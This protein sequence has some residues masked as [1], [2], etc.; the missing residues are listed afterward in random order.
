[1]DRLARHIAVDQR[2]R[3]AFG[4]V[5]GGLEGAEAGRE[6]DRARPLGA[7]R[8]PDVPPPDLVAGALDQQPAGR[9]PR[10]QPPPRGGHLVLVVL[11]QHIRGPDEDRRPRPLTRQ[12]HLEATV[13]EVQP[14]PLIGPRGRH[15]RRVDLDADDPGVRPDRPQPAQQLHRGP[16]RGAVTEV[17]GD[18]VGGAAQ[19]GAVFRGDP[20]V[21]TAQ[22]VGVGCPAG[23]V[24]DGAGGCARR[25]G[26][27]D[28]GAAG[29]G[30]ESMG[31]PRVHRPRRPAGTGRGATGAPPG[32]AGTAGSRPGPPAPACPARSRF[33]KVRGGRAERKWMA[34]VCC[35]TGSEARRRPA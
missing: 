15:P 20:A 1:M 4:Q 7:Q 10:A 11:P 3:E 33:G 5:R 22:P 13:E 35:W 29:H 28:G 27:G 12:R 8:H 9:Q 32:R 25:G 6:G 30:I 17:D 24:A 2:L 16:G 19:H 18:G 34:A 21:H 23:G 26:G 31:W 14:R